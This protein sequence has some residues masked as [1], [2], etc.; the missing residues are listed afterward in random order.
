MNSAA[1]LRE[2]LRA[3]EV[4]VAPGAYDALSARIIERVGFSAVYLTGAG[5]TGALLGMTDLGLITMTELVQVARNVVMAVRLPV[6]CDSDTG[7]G[8]AIN[9]RRTVRE[10]ERAGVAGIH[11]EDQ[12]WPKRCGHFEGKALIPIEEMAQ[13]IRAASDVRENPDFV[14]IARTDAIAVE[15]FEAALARGE[16]YLEGGAD[17][18]F[19][20][21]PR[22]IEQV[23]AIG[24]RFGK[25]IP[26]LI[27]MAETGKAPIPAGARIGAAGI[28]G[29]DLSRHGAARGG[30]GG[31]G[32]AAS[33][34]ADRFH[35]E[36]EGQDDLV[37]RMDGTHGLT[38]SDRAGTPLRRRCE[39]LAGVYHGGVLARW[40]DG[41]RAMRN[42]SF[43]RPPRP[44]PNEARSVGIACSIATGLPLRPPIFRQASDEW[45]VP[46]SSMAIAT[47]GSLSSGAASRGSPRKAVGTP[48]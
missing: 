45:P 18:F 27:N 34:Q 35:D 41:C 37:R 42:A 5:I 48:S 20:D 26:L 3:P 10:F 29:G 38:R 19:V 32:R 33:A 24:A 6:I 16:A 2:L 1:R 21:G 36:R 17:M 13:K 25:R 11:I 15:G 4:L 44:R 28:Q 23:Q 43:F 30:E 40:C 46:K 39:A 7:F 8:N 9:T 31:H 14:I 22:T 47:P 12:V